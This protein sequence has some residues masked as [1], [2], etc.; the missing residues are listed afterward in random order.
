M[1]EASAYSGRQ[2]EDR[3][4]KLRPERLGGKGD[5]RPERLGGTGELRPERLGEPLKVREIEERL[6]QLP[7]WRAVEGNRA[8]AR[9]FLFPSLRA[10]VGFV[11]MV[12][13]IGEADGYVPEIDL[14]LLEVTVRVSTNVN[15]GL[16]AL[17]FQVARSLGLT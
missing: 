6:A 15:E 3:A 1:S 5:L 14:R 10:A 4:G 13:E 9:T 17:D 2:P 12:T 11:G 16:T 8:L 7:G